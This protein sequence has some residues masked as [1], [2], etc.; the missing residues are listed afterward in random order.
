MGAG[1][2]VQIDPADDLCALGIDNRLGHIGPNQVIFGEGRAGGQQ[3]EKGN[4]ISQWSVSVN[5]NTR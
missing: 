4:R 2:Q 3:G 5:F 1:L